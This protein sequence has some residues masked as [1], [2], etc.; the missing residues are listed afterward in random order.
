MTLSFVPK[1]SRLPLSA[2]ARSVAQPLAVPV[3]P[4]AAAAGSGRAVLAQAVGAGLDAALAQPHGRALRRA[5]GADLDRPTAQAA[6]HREA[7]AYGRQ[8]AGVFGAALPLL[9][10]LRQRMGRGTPDCELRGRDRLAALAAP[11]LGLIARQFS[12]IDARVVVPQEKVDLMNPIDAGAGDALRRQVER[13]QAEIGDVRSA[14]SLRMH[15]AALDALAAPPPTRP[16]APAALQLAQLASAASTIGTA[17]VM[18]HS[19]ATVAVAEAGALRLR[20]ERAAAAGAPA[21]DERA[22][23]AGLSAE[24]VPLFYASQAGTAGASAVVADSAQRKRLGGMLAAVEQDTQALA[25][26]ARALR[27]P[28]ARMGG[29]RPASRSGPP[30]DV[31]VLATLC[32][33]VAEGLHRDDL[34]AARPPTALCVPGAQARVAEG[35]ARRAILAMGHAVGMHAAARPWFQPSASPASH[36]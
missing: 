19:A 3:H 6:A 18:R 26:V 2:V 31:P 32:D 10:A 4:S 23:L 7:V 5:L 24:P 15:R 36:A 1:S 34:V 29:A 35:P 9:S 27:R 11:L 12:R 14:A 25:G 20:A 33:V 21:A 28:L 17:M 16:G 30:A 8:R 22:G 13:A